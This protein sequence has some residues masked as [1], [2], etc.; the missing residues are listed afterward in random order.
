MRLNTAGSN[1]AKVNH[2]FPSGNLASPHSSA[3]AAR[4]RLRVLLLA[5]EFHTWDA[6]A[7]HVSYASSLGLEEGLRACDVEL[8]TITTPWFWKARDLCRGRSFDQVWIEISRYEHFTDDWLDWM[9]S[10]APVRLGLLAE[11]RTYRPE[12]IS[13]NPAFFTGATARV[14]H[15][16][17]YVTHAA[18]VDERDAQ[19]IGQ[20]FVP[21]IW[22]PQSVPRRFIVDD[23]PAALIRHVVFGGSFY[24]RRLGLLDRPEVKAV[25]VSQP[26]SERGTWYPYLFDGLHMIVRMME[27]RAW[28]GGRRSMAAYLVL[29]RR[30]RRVCFQ[31]WLRSMQDGC[32]VA[33]LPSC[34]KAY[35]SRVP[36]AMAAGRPVISWRVPDRPR[37]E[38]LFKDGRE[39]LLFEQD[40]PE[41]LVD[42]ARRLIREEDL[43]RRMVEAATAKLRRFHTSEHRIGQILDWLDNAVAPDFGE[44]A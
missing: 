32:A 30:L 17:Q 43:G 42:H 35:A 13:I 20:R 24:G 21:A 3:G 8:T 11:S 37:T 41:Q 34:V 5:L 15:R 40:R 39:I 7:R 26:S 23:P 12:E 27:R 1:P 44:D 10:L 33:N 31:R 19:E 36:E 28:P 16:L 2:L 18:A 38:A 4:G 25:L 9:S 29:L 6:L 14:D 22:W